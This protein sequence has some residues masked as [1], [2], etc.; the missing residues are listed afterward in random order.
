[1]KTELQNKAQFRQQ[2]NELCLCGSILGTPSVQSSPDKMKFPTAN[3]PFHF[4][5][6][7][8]L[9]SSRLM[10]VAEDIHHEHRSN[11]ASET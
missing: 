3:I 8:H 5:V 4:T 10:Q 7:C 1:M 6:C 11:L 2:T 9:L